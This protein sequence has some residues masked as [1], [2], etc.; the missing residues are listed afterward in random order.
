MYGMHHNREMGQQIFKYLIYGII[1][2]L[3]SDV[4][5]F[6]FFGDDW[7]HACRIDGGL[8]GGIRKFTL[9][10]CFLSFCFRVFYTYI[11]IVLYDHY[12]LEGLSGL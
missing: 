7:M 10:M 2:S 11:Y 3:L 1:F 8:E 9:A 5:W 12:S 4:L 6:V